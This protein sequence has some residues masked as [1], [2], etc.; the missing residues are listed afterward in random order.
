V[1]SSTVHASISSLI[2]S[3]LFM[4]HLSGGCRVQSEKSSNRQILGRITAAA[5]S[6]ENYSRSLTILLEGMT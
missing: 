4:E 2:A 1:S 3:S 5:Q 6:A